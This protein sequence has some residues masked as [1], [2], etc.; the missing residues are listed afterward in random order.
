MLNAVFFAYKVIL[1]NTRLSFSFETLKMNVVVVYCSRN[2]NQRTTCKKSF[3]CTMATV[4]INGFGRIG[5]LVLRASLTDNKGISEMFYL[6]KLWLFVFGI[7]NQENNTAQFYCYH[8]GQANR[9][10]IEVYTFLNDYISELDSVKELHVFSDPCG[11]QNR[12][13][14]V[15]SRLFYDAL[16]TA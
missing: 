12:N 2:R 8:E 11:G 3:S 15:F 7:H 6:R 16:S 14:T 13:N 9:N 5:R 4:G 10:P 1:S